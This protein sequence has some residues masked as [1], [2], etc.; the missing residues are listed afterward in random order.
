MQEQWKFDPDNWGVDSN[1]GYGIIA[2]DED[3]VES[4]L[5]V[6]VHARGLWGID[7]IDLEAQ[8]AQAKATARLITAA[9][10][11]RDALQELASTTS[12][13]FEVLNQAK[14]VDMPDEV[15]EAICKALAA[16]KLATTH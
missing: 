11:M 9:P 10:A 1:P 16:V 15:Q 12:E 6:T 8:E 5:G 14:D 3:G 2:V 4:S 7:P 13:A